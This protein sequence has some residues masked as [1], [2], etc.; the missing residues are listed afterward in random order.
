MDT[1]HGAAAPA[2]NLLSRNIREYSLFQGVLLVM[3]RLR[4]EY[5]ERDE[6]A[7]YNLIEFQANP[8]MGFP[9]SDIERVELFRED[10][11]TRARLRLNLISLFGAGSPLPAFY[12]EQ[13]LGDSLEINPTR[14]FLDL[15]NNRLQRLLL[16]IWQK[17]RYYSRF[18]TGALD[19]FSSQL[20]SLVGLGSESIRSGS[21]LNWKR[22]LPYLG[23]LSL[24]VQSAAVI[25]SVLRYYFRHQAL[26]IEQCM[27]R[28][29]EIQKHQRNGLGLANSALGNSLVIGDQVRDR[30]GRFR[31]HIQQLDWERFH[32]F[33]PTGTGFRPLCALVR[34][35]LR[36]PLD[37]DIR[38]Q[39]CR[40]A[41]RELR[42]EADTPC[43]LGWT[44]WLGSEAIDA[45]ADP[46]VTLSST[47]S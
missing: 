11:E 32:E 34:F 17:Y 36:D 22:L 6:Q 7:L 20:F 18:S 25:E 31:I 5:P 37:Y 33:L 44:S 9:G 8:S 43:L 24:R 3:E 40:H 26:H 28:Q 14:Q 45:C 4:E 47:V 23:L 13:A 12:G 35:A 30:S 42:L 21:Q 39:L 38:L 27:E 2:L 16:P 19:P 46:A 1:T 10:G 41:V 29:V 15:F